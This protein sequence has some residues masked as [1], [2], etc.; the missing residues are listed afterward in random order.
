MPP[1]SY[2]VPTMKPGVFWRKTSGTPRLQQSSTKWAPLCAAPRGGRVVAG[3]GCAGGRPADEDRAG[4]PDDDRLVAH[5]RHVGAAR[6]ARAHHDRY[7]RDPL[8]GHLR[9]VEEDAAEVL[10]VGEDL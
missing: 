9:L 2:S 4:P 1:A 3:L 10:A 7:L 6:G 5:R 8:R